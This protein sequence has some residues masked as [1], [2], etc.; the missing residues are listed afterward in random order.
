M[1]NEV[2]VGR[3]IPVDA[4]ANEVGESF[5][6]LKFIHSDTLDG[7]QPLRWQLVDSL[8][9]SIADFKSRPSALTEKYTTGINGPVYTNTEYACRL[10]APV[11]TWA[12]ENKSKPGVCMMRFVVP[13]ADKVLIHFVVFALPSGVEPSVIV[14]P[15][16]NMFQK[17]YEKF[18]VLRNEPMEIHGAKGHTLRFRRAAR[19]DET[20]TMLTTEYIW[21]HNSAGYLLNL[22]AEESAHEMYG[23]DFERLLESFEFLTEK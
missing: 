9:V 16:L 22:I 21:V 13:G 12:I 19:G 3:W 7:T 14:S 8:N 23:A 5:A 4:A 6:L 15:R 18:E 1:W 17:T 10:T 20:G 2:F 11:E